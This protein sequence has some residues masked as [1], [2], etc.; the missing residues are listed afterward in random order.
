MRLPGLGDLSEDELVLLLRNRESAALFCWKPFMH[1][2]KLRARLRAID[3]PTLVLWGE[4]DR[5]VSPQYG[6]AYA[7]GISGATFQIVR[8]AG[9]YPYLEQPEAFVELAKRF[10]FTKKAAVRTG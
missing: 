2:P 8:S 10:L 5:L 3:V 1:N 4:S 9:H 6:Q 7:D